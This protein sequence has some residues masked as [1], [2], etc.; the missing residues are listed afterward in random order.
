[1]ASTHKNKSYKLKNIYILFFLRGPVNVLIRHYAEVLLW[2]IC[3]KLSLQ[4]WLNLFYGNVRQKIMN[5][6]VLL[7]FEF[8]SK[9][10]GPG[11]S[12]VELQVR[13][14]IQCRQ[15]ALKWKVLCH[16]SEFLSIMFTER[17]QNVV[18]AGRSSTLDSF[19]IG[20]DIFWAVILTHFV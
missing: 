20:H 5:K 12:S 10:F 6:T 18:M 2:T 11:P 19:E 14:S 16:K 4:E 1:M 13:C 17:C 8:L 7:W 15:Q 9:G 3:G